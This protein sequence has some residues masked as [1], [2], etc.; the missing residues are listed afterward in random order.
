MSVRLDKWLW[1]ARFYKT[2]ALAKKAIE[3]GKVHFQGQKTKVSKIVNIGDTYQIQQ[4]YIK[5]TVIVEALDEV[6]K[7]ASE[8]QKL[9]RETAESIEKREQETILRKTANLISPEKPTKKQR[10]QI[11]DFKRND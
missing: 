6:R 10:R 1:A 5:K 2:R 11:I 9:Y 3:G 8:A 4:G 7:S